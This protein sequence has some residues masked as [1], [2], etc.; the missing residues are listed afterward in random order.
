MLQILPSPRKIIKTLTALFVG[1]GFVFIG[2]SLVLT[3]AGVMLSDMGVEN[4][5]IG[6]IT[7][8]FFI[9]AI[10]S[11]IFTYK[12]ISTYG[13]IRSYAIFTALFA[14]S[15]LLHVL[16]DNVIYWVFLR[17]M[18]GFSYYSIVMVAESWINTRSRNEIRS[19][20]LSFYSTIYYMAFGIGVIILSF[21]LTPVKIFIV[22]IFFIIVGSI[23]MNIIKI[24]EPKLPPKKKLFIPNVFN[25]VPLA[26][27]TS[28]SAGILIN[29]FFAMSGLFII[30]SGGSIA[31]ASFF[32]FAAMVG[33]FLSQIFFGNFSDRFGRKYAIILSS[34]IALIASIL[35]YI[36]MGNMLIMKLLAFLLGFGIFCLYALAAARAN[37]VLSEQDSRVEVGA[38]ILLSFS[39]GSILGP[40]SMGLLMQ[41]FGSS[42]FVFIYFTFTSFLII[43]S[44]FKETVPKKYRTEYL[45][46]GPSE[47]L[48]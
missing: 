5:Y 28:F 46:T 35:M 47:V 37:D 15:A 17:I 30:A 19:R 13:Y 2:N 12:F 10:L 26:L 4:F 3:S 38:S 25:L 43:F 40:I 1:V 41:I 34:S 39:I 6:I 42:G 21:K 7:A 33:G 29:G 22:S 23:P 32:L 16:G 18:L 20:V 36:F 31:D 27:V 8:C 45:S 11:S 48:D 14:I 44:I 24:K 9:G